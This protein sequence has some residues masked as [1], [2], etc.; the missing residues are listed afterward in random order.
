MKTIVSV[1]GSITLERCYRYC[2]HC[3][4]YSFPVEA[5]LGLTKGYTKTVNRYASRLCGLVSY[6][7]ASDT[8]EEL[9]AVS[10]SPTKIGDIADE[11][12]GEIAAKQEDCPAFQEALRTLFQEAAGEPEFYVDGTCVHIRNADGTHEWREFKLGAFAKRVRGLFALPSEWGTRKLP[13]PTAV[14]A[15]ALIK[16]TADCRRQTAEEVRSTAIFR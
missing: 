3:K 8:L 2:R 12:A 13:H 4:K 15:F 10:I 9:C 5:T 7:V 11:V 16:K 1:H 14:S 6:R